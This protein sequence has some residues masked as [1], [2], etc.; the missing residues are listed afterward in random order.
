MQAI[1]LPV[2]DYLGRMKQFVHMKFIKF[3]TG[4]MTASDSVRLN[5][6]TDSSESNTH[7]IGYGL[8]WLFVLGESVCSGRDCSVSISVPSVITDTQCAL[9]VYQR[10]ECYH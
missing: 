1:V 4:Q 3:A 7:A 10:S 9:L 2:G 6:V 5:G 8:D